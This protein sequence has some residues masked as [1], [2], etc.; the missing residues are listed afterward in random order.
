MRIRSGWHGYGSPALVLLA[1]ASAGFAAA[2]GGSAAST[3]SLT[4]RTGAGRGGQRPTVAVE[5][6]TPVEHM[7]VHRQVDLSGTLLS[8]EQA[9]VSSEVDGRVQEV[10]VQLGTIVQTGAVLVRLD[11]RE[12]QLAVDRAESAL[13][14]VLAQLGIPRGQNIEPPPDEQIATVR[15][16]SANLEDARAT[17]A[18]TEQLGGRGLLSKVDRDTAETRFKV[19]EANYQA[20]VDAVRALKASLQDRRAAFALAQKKLDDAAIHA[21][22]AGSVSE[23]LVQPGEFIKANTPVVTIVQMSPLKL[24]TALQEK[25]ASVIKPGQTVDFAVEAYP[26]ETFTGRLAYISPAVDQATRTFTVEAIVANQDGRLKPGFFAN[27]VV[28][29]KLDEHVTALPEDAISTLAGVSSVYVIEDGKI[30][31]QTVS[32][33]T[34]Q[35]KLVEVTDGLKGNETLAASNL[36]QLATGTQVQIGKADGRGARREGSGQ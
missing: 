14:Q 10:L 30:R 13:N 36:S 17:F 3:A 2:C 22:V 29:T 24:R 9:R 1:A 16:A 21:P 18:R 4:G 19:S 25:F 26:G 15:Q 8:P 27:G 23:R 28:G 7:A 12:L 35:G 6:T 34:R 20:A 33:G 32:L 11:T 31:Q 5:R